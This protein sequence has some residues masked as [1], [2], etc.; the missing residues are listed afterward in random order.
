MSCKDYFF[1]LYG[2]IILTI[3][4]PSHTKQWMLWNKNSLSHLPDTLG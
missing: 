1:L 2:E 3:A 4:S